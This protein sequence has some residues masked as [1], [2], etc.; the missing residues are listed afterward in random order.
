MLGYLSYRRY[1]DNLNKNVD[2]FVQNCDVWIDSSG[3]IE[4]VIKK[5]TIKFDPT[6]FVKF[7]EKIETLTSS[8]KGVR[9]IKLDYLT[10]DVDPLHFHLILL[11]TLTLMLIHGTL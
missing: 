1:Q 4:D 10:R 6:K 2:I 11:K 5:S 8:V 9:G 7:R 3:D